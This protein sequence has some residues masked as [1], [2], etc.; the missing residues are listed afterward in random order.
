MESAKEGIRFPEATFI[1]LHPRNWA[2][3]AFR[4]V[5]TSLETNIPVIRTRFNDKR[6]VKG[7]VASTIFKEFD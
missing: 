4:K 2:K 5:H 3:R 7:K 6:K 1:I